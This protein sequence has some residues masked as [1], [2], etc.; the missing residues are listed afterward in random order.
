MEAAGCAF[1]VGR[2]EQAAAR[3]A[4]DSASLAQAWGSFAPDINPESPKQLAEYLYETRGFPVPPVAGTLKAVKRTRRGERPTGEASLDWLLRKA[5]RPEN[6][7]LL[8]C[9]MKLRKVTK[10]NQFLTKLPAYVDDSGFLYAS[11][12]PDTGTGRLSSRN[13]NLQN[14]PGAKNDAYGIRACFVAPAGYRLLVADYGALEL[15][16][17]AHWL[18]ALFGDDSLARALAS[19]DVYG[20]VAV[21]TWPGRVGS[22]GAGHLKE[23][24]DP[25]IRKIRDD[26]KIIVLSSN[27]GKT[28]SGLAAQLNCS[29]EEATAQLEAYFHAYPGIPRFQAWA[30]EQAGADGVRTLLGRTRVIPAGSTPGEVARAARQATNTVIQGSAADVVFAAMIKQAGLGGILQ[31]QIHDELV[32][33]VPADMDVTPLIQAMEHPFAQDLLVPLPVEWKLVDDWSQAK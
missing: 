25:A 23:H 13:V 31:M 33:R 8:A 5:K 11:F 1:D 2:C 12:G 10:L 15:R 21:E 20:A 6:K 9:L 3:T 22:V 29:V 30:A 28:P 17:L 32:W 18:V 24:P 16:I 26:A 14:L 4:A 27:Y 7:E 19:G